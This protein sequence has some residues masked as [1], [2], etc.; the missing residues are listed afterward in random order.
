MQTLLSS[1]A[2]TLGRSSAQRELRWMREALVAPRRP[3]TPMPT[4][5]QMVERRIAGE[6]LQ[7]ILGTQP[8]GP[9]NLRV[10]PP[11][12][13]PRPET[14]EWTLRVAE[15]L[16]PTRPKKTRILD[17]CTGT[18][19]IPLLLCTSWAPQPVTALGVDISADALALARENAEDCRADFAGGL[20]ESTID[21]LQADVLSDS[22]A[23][24]LRAHPACG[25]GFDL[26]TSNPPYIPLGEWRDLDASVKEW[27]DPRA[28]IGDPGD[29]PAHL[30]PEQA[31]EGQQQAGRRGLAFYRALARLAAQPGILASGCPLVM[32]VGHDQA[33]EVEDILQGT[34]DGMAGA[35]D[36]A[37]ARVERWKDAWDVERVVIGWKH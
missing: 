29:W 36:Q 28:L 16:R 20:K 35:R 6:P 10:R 32:E 7:Y 21:F 14:E 30:Q 8:F 4:L 26:I 33:G 19:C 17:L 24:A 1:L 11:T 34:H 9:L 27:E 25:P 22:F 18:G 5:E 23:D 2:R 3:A 31:A 12:L 37:F 13:I 15:L